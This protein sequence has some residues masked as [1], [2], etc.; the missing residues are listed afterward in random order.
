MEKIVERIEK[1]VHIR[2]VT[3]PVEKI[4]EKVVEKRVPVD[5][6]VQKKVPVTIE[7]IVE[8]EKPRYVQKVCCL[9]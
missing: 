4:V 9:L 5:K 7:K 3:V 6:V 8:I 2:E 1:E